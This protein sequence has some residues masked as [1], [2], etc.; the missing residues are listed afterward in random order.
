VISSLRGGK[1]GAAAVS[2]G[3]TS[4]ARQDCLSATAHLGPCGV[5]FVSA[6]ASQRATEVY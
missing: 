4:T 3:G 5:P 2:E 6:E 1:D